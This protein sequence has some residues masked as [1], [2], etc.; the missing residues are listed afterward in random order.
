MKH[1]LELRDT[2]FVCDQPV[3]AVW[4]EL[5]VETGVAEGP[6]QCDVRLT[7]GEKSYDMAP[8]ELIILGKAME[9]Y[10]EQ[11][12]ADARLEHQLQP[13]MRFVG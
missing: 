13:N 10:L 8:G 6:F 4:V 12:R 2:E 1:I 7:L 11:R 3:Q 5:V 9:A